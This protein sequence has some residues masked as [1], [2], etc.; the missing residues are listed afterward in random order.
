ML[1]SLVKVARVES[2]RLSKL[3]ESVDV[4]SKDPEG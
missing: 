4:G 1:M 3:I 2:V